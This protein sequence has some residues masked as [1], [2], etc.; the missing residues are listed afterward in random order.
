MPPSNPRKNRGA[1]GRTLPT[2][3]AGTALGILDEAGLP[4]HNR[5]PKDDK[6]NPP[7]EASLNFPPIPDTYQRAANQ[8][9]WLPSLAT[10]PPCRTA[11][12]DATGCQTT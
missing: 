10:R 7:R 4:D 8:R 9:G 3:L 12:V 5:S 1:F 2:S 11:S 6:T